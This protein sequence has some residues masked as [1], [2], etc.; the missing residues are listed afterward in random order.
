M[1]NR[2][3]SV[4]PVWPTVQHGYRQEKMRWS[5]ATD[6]LLVMFVGQVVELFVVEAAVRVRRRKR[7]PCNKKPQKREY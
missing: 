3:R 5:L 7:G 2:P 4:R 6:R 1:F